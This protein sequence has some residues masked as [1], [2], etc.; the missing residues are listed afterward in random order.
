[1]PSVSTFPPLAGPC[2]CGL[3]ETCS[4]LNLTLQQVEGNTTIHLP[5]NITLTQAGTDGPDGVLNLNKVMNT[6]KKYVTKIN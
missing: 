6:H 3:E 5:T 1:M 4:P 2:H